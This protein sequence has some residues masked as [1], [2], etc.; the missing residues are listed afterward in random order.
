LHVSCYAHLSLSDFL[1][2]R[3]F[4]FQIIPTILSQTKPAPSAVAFG[5]P[6]DHD[7]FFFFFF[8]VLYHHP[9]IHP[10]IFIPVAQATNSF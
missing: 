1:T 8:F 4:G 5:N 10:S 6:V 3:D 7:L 9:S 2:T